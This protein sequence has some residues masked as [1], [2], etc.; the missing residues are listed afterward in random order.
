MK[1]N[2][3]SYLNQSDNTKLQNSTSVYDIKQLVNLSLL[4][5][6]SNEFCIKEGLFEIIHRARYMKVKHLIEFKFEKSC[7]NKFIDELLNMKIY[8][9]PSIRQNMCRYLKN[10]IEITP[11]RRIKV[12]LIDSTVINQYLHK[13]AKV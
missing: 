5:T 7:I 8:L 13:H 9:H 1:T 10:E 2:N 4:P 12:R 11:E 3:S 6:L